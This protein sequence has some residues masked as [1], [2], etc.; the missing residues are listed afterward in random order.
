[1]PGH[2]LP[3]VVIPQEGGDQEP[4]AQQ[5][6]ELG[7]GVHV[8]G[9]TPSVEEIRQAI[10]RVLTEPSFAATARELRTQIRALPPLDTAVT[11]LER[12]VVDGP[13]S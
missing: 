9:P 2:G 7:L 11:R 8:P 1:M 12:L 13:P 10:V 3:L 4:T 6:T 5:V